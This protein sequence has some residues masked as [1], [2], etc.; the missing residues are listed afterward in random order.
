MEDVNVNTQYTITPVNLTVDK[1]FLVR[2]NFVPTIQQ[3]YGQKK[4]ASYWDYYKFCN[5]LAII[6][7]FCQSNLTT[8]KRMPTIIVTKGEKND[9]IKI[10]I[11]E[12]D[13]FLSLL[14]KDVQIK[15]LQ[16]CNID[17][18]GLYNANFYNDLP[19]VFNGF[20]NTTSV[21]DL[22][23]K[24]YHFDDFDVK[25][26]V[27]ET[28]DFNLQ[29]ILHDTQLK[30][31]KLS[32]HQVIEQTDKI[33]NTLKT[34]KLMH[35]TVHSWGVFVNRQ[36]NANPK[37]RIM[38][39]QVFP[40]SL[41]FP[42]IDTPLFTQKAR[43][44]FRHQDDIKNIVVKA[45]KRFFSDVI[46][47]CFLFEKDKCTPYIIVE[48]ITFCDE[49]MHE[50]KIVHGTQKKIFLKNHRIEIYQYDDN[51]LKYTSDK[52]CQ[53][54][55]L[56]LNYANPLKNNKPSVFNSYTNLRFAIIDFFRGS[57][58]VYDRKRKRYACFSLQEDKDIVIS[59]DQVKNN[60]KLQI[61]ETVIC[62]CLLSSIKKLPD[63]KA[64]IKRKRREHAKR[65]YNLMN[66]TIP[67][68]ISLLF[69]LI[70][71]NKRNYFYDYFQF[72]LQKAKSRS[73]FRNPLLL[74]QW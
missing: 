14:P 53:I 55:K 13:V 33:I 20:L 73:N 35:N 19:F 18:N 74:I 60:I 23:N 42:F 30:E 47:S 28:D 51:I 6:A 34:A 15:I 50:P 16:F 22:A 70:L 7:I 2:P 54:I 71:Y 62:L 65:I 8:E 56:P 32:A 58:I 25:P 26:L 45:E 44:Y 24:T 69:L 39:F 68:A 61:A 38:T 63:T 37:N 4:M 27:N 31:K 3:K 52:A 49:I 59:E 64:S 36:F 41:C 1:D 17:D 66:N 67:W 72:T 11:C 5:N 40:E 29:I 57:I 21:Y 43:R 46:I 12:K 10:E 48:L 9:L